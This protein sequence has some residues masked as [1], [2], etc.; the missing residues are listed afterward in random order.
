MGLF[1]DMK[2]LYHLALRPVRGKNHAERMESFYSGQAEAYDDF[3]KRLLHGREELF[4]AIEVPEGGVWVDLGGGTGANMEFIADRVPQLGQAYVVDLASSLLK[5]ASSRFE[6]H[7]WDHVSAVE[8]DATKWQPPE[9]QADVVTF[10]YSLTMIPD[11][12]SAIEN[13]LRMLK[14]GGQ[15]GVVDFYATRKHAAEG[16]QRHGWFT[17]TF[18]PVWFSTDNVF[19]ST[20]H[21]P[22]LRSHCE[23][24]LCN[25]RRSKVPYIPLI[26]TPYYQYI[27]RK[28]G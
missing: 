24:V 3:R 17:R 5:V 25:E 8:A 14:P 10:S 26:R 21:L 2:I 9:G 22:F 12:F 1:Q 18:W 20:D 6:S 16:M 27:G 4:Q 15:I 13:A 23:T 7:G 19:P 28:R 11:W